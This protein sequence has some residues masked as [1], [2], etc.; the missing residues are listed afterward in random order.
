[1]F[2]SKTYFKKLTTLSLLG[3][4]VLYFAQEKAQVEHANESNL[5]KHIIYLASDELQGRLTGSEG[6]T[7]AANYL[8]AEL[9]KLGLKPYEGKDF[10]QNFEYSVK[11]NPHDDQTSTPVKGK[12]VIAVLDNKADKTIVIGAHY[13]HLGL[14]EHH[15][16][17]L[18]DKSTT[19]RMITLL[20]QPLFWN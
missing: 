11:L 4:S 9:K 3:I 8:S 13:D 2:L 19:V 16:S 15:N 18:P 17:T 5:E 12:N 7:K 10:I 20:E 14:N 6:E 1:M